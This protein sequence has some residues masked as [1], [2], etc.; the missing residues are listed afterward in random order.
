MC[1]SPALAVGPMSAFSVCVGTLRQP[2]SRWPWAAMI[3]STTCLHFA[4]S[5]A[6]RRQKHDAGRELA[7]RRQLGLQLL[8]HDALQKLVRQRGEDAGAV[9]RVRLAAARAAVVHVVERRCATTC[10]GCG[11]GP[12]PAAATPNVWWMPTS[13]TSPE[14]KRRCWPA[15]SRPK[16]VRL[17]RRPP[18]RRRPPTGTARAVGAAGR[19][20]SPRCGSWTTGARSATSTCPARRPRSPCRSR[21][22]R[23]WTTSCSAWGSSRRTACRCTARTPPGGVRP[24]AGRGTGEVRLVLEDLRLV[25]GTYLV[26]VAAHRRDG[27]PYDYHRGLHTFR[28]KS[29]IKDVG[30]YRPATTGTSRAGSTWRR[31][32][33]SGAGPHEE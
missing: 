25:E 16:A 14:G 26:D 19:W 20:R 15:R 7:R 27:T 3:S 5:A 1:G 13:P 23:P 12:W 32:P 33:P 30:V 6:S 29:R 2:T 31:R 11:G 4:R 21:R 17:R 28:M 22:V 10:C 24:A 18:A 9:A 8:P